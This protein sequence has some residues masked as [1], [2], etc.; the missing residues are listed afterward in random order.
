M[1][2]PKQTV[3]VVFFAS[4]VAC[5]LAVLWVVL[6]DPPID[7]EK[8]KVNRARTDIKSLETAITSYMMANAHYPKTL[9]ELTKPDPPFNPAL[10]VE[11]A[12]IDPWKQP[13]HYDPKKLDPYTN[14]PKIWSDGRPGENKPISN[15]D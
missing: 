14:K 7:W 4:A 15:W 9:E 1:T 13:Y 12:L 8:A 3:A 6:F 5:G 2:L 11:K 10:L